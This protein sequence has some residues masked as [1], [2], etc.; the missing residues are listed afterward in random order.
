[1]V[2]ELKLIP[3]STPDTAVLI[4]DYDVTEKNKT[5]LMYRYIQKLTALGVEKPGFRFTFLGLVQNP[6]SKKKVNKTVALEC[7][8]NILEH[9]D[10]QGITTLL[11]TDA[12]YFQLLTGRSKLEESI[13]GVYKVVITGFEHITV[14]PSLH[15]NALIMAPQKESVLEKSLK[16]LAMHLNG[17]YSKPGADVL[18]D[19]TKCYSANELK[20]VLNEYM[21]LPEITCDIEATHL[22]FYKSEL[23]T[24]AFGKDKHTAM[25]C[26]VHH[27]YHNQ[28]ESNS[29][30]QVLKEFF[31]N[32]KG[33]VWFHNA[34]F[35][36]KQ[37][38]YRLF[39]RSLD[40]FT[41]MQEGLD[42]FENVHDTFMVAYLAKNSTYRQGLGLKEL[43]KEFMGEY[44]EDVK[45]AIKVPLEDLM[46]YN[47]KDCCATWYVLDTYRPI[48]IQD[49]QQY[50]YDTIMQP[51]MKPLL[52]MMLTG[53][54][55]DLGRTEEARIEL[56][57]KLD[58]AVNTLNKSHYVKRAV[59]V[60]KYNAAEKYNATHKT[61]K[62]NANDVELEFNPNSSDQLRLLLF[63][64]LGFE[65]IEKTKAGK[66]STKR[67]FIEEYLAEAKADGESDVVSCLEALVNVSQISI[68]LNTFITAFE[69]LSVEH[70]S[71]YKF[72]KGNLKLG[73]TQSGRLSSSEPNLQNLPSGSKY[74]KII[75]NCFVAPKGWLFAG[76]DFSALEDRIGAILSNDMNKT[77]EFA[78]GF[79]GHSLRA[80]AFF[81]EELPEGLSIDSL[82][83]N[84]LI[85]KQYGDI[86]GKSKGPSFAMQYGCGPGKIQQLLK[87]SKAKAEEVYSAF[88]NLYSGLSKFAQVNKIQGMTNG[89]VTGAFGLRLRTPKLKA[90]R[91]GTKESTEV[92]SEARSASNMV[93][94]SWGMLM[95]RALIEFNQ[96]LENSE[97]KHKVRL[98]NTIHD[99]GYL[100]VK[101]EPEVVEW[102][103]INF[104]E[105]MKW[106]DGLIASDEVKMEAEVDFGLDWAHQETLHNNASKEECKAFI[107]AINMY[108]SVKHLEY[109]NQPVK[110]NVVYKL[111][112]EGFDNLSKLITKLSEV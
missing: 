72:L 109:N 19:Y 95:N 44:A 65:E 96:R 40:D 1:M 78:Y 33:K 31:I 18:K 48:M 27:L 59:S 69:E 26:A 55:I 7:L 63:E 10:I 75:K 88:H 62:I 103:N 36:V 89:Y 85:K 3:N 66:S 107:D 92:G 100:L 77:K 12:T 70:P 94:Q 112:L 29:I 42:A 25:T 53:L 50:V 64:I 45:E 4:K 51:S 104:V 56:Q 60:L 13:D 110:F 28:L 102:V 30:K 49:D 32:Y 98:I 6:D 58:D 23:L 2:K 86:R 84:K 111:A 83:D 90:H 41:G 22:K 67:N 11:C 93:T 39:M 71:G 43:S 5:N 46:L 34:L 74:G 8:G 37:L 20:R 91:A 73:G 21:V 101:A 97:F 16:V 68:I 79:D 80:L 57:A 108:D 38:T 9:C 17:S 47:A 105:C 52:K 14:L 81:P 35:D 15:Y 61:K 24:I 106:Q 76:A 99:A 87:C 82:E 54:P